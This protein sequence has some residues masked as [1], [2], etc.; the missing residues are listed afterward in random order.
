M[1]PKV[2][3]DMLIA[4]PLWKMKYQEEKAS[5]EPQSPCLNTLWEFRQNKAFGAWLWNIHTS[6]KEEKPSGKNMWV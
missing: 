4:W 3:N 2:V 1:Q 6:S 5:Y